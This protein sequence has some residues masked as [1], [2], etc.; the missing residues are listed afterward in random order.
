[1]KYSPKTTRR[2]PTSICHSVIVRYD[3][4]RRKWIHSAGILV[5]PREATVLEALA[6]GHG[7]AEM[8]KACGVT[9]D[10]FYAA[11]ARLKKYFGITARDAKGHRELLKIAMDLYA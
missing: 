8:A 1:M 9:T 3:F 6:N 10:T 2:N 5:T 7:P 11:Q 4:D